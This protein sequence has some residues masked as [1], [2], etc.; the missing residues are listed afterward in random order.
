MTINGS[1]TVGR[2][3]DASQEIKPLTGLEASHQACSPC[4]LRSLASRIPTTAV[5]DGCWGVEVRECDVLP[6]QVG[7]VGF[8][9]QRP[10]SGDVTV[11]C[12]PR[13][14]AVFEQGGNHV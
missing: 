10:V 2:L 12:W 3:A 14:W 8:W 1:R 6:Q 13:M 5:R 7:L 9:Q 4:L 11:G